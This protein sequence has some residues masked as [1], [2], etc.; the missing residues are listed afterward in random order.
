[1]L[2]HGILG[3]KDPAYLRG[4]ISSLALFSNGSVAFLL[5]YESWGLLLVYEY[6][7]FSDIISRLD[8]GSVEQRLF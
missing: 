4:H 6:R 2:Y 1:M 7:P 3:A 8:S 5:L